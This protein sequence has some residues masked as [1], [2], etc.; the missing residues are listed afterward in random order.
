[1]LL[2]MLLASD[3]GDHLPVGALLD[4]AS[5]GV[6]ATLGLLPGMDGRQDRPLRDFSFLIIDSWG[7]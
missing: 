5:I 2:T 7:G 4:R 6:T 3:E 1:M